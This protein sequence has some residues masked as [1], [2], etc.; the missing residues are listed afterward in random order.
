[1]LSLLEEKYL[2]LEKARRYI[3]LRSLLE[4]W[5]FIHIPATI[6]LIGALAAHIISVFFW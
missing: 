5:L 2:T 4:V 1:V 6:A 3:R